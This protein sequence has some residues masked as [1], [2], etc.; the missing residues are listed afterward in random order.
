MGRG[1]EKT[2][3]EARALG[4]V[5]SGFFIPYRYAASAR[6]ASST[7]AEKI[8]HRAGGRFLT[9]L[10]EIDG[11]ASE[12]E[13]IGNEPPPAPRWTQ[14]WFPRL[15]AAAAYAIVR[16]RRPE[17]IVEV[18][19]GHSTRFLARAV[20][21]G[22]LGT[23]ITAIDPAP[24]A[25]FEGLG[26]DHVVSLAQD[27]PAAF[28]AL[29][30]GDIL[31]ID[32][33]HVL[34]PGT[35]VDFLF[36]AVLPTLPAGIFIHIHDVMLPDPYPAEWSWRGYNE[37]SAV[38]ALLGTGAYE[39]LFSSRFVATRLAADAAKTVVARLPLLPGAHET[40]LWLRKTAPAVD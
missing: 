16:G 14:D 32:S 39:P 19:S 21:D 1:R 25:S 22:A 23:R 36:G 12:L 9:L 40:S 13:R 37:Q 34:M 10:C 27:S 8:L 29:G 6:R 31:F 28:E 7:V 38:A 15:D 24:R 17:R 3:E 30:P 4:L 35:D 5:P 20:A 11:F 18:G 26:I 33:S 2:I